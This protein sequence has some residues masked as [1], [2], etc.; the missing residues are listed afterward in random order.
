MNIISIK[1]S[2]CLALTILVLFIAFINKDT[3]S[4]YLLSSIG[5]IT[6]CLTFKFMSEISK[7]EIK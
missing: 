5:I 1:T 4:G 7:N 6:G 3:A 2:F